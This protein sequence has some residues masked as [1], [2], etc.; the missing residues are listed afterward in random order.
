[1][2]STIVVYQ[3]ICILDSDEP[4]VLRPSIDDIDLFITDLLTLK[5]SHNSKLSPNDSKWLLHQWLTPRAHTII[6][7]RYE[8]MISSISHD[9]QNVASGV[10]DGDDETQWK[11]YDEAPYVPTFDELKLSSADLTYLFNDCARHAEII[12]STA[13]KIFLRQ[14]SGHG[15]NSNID[16]GQPPKYIYHE[17]SSPFA[18]SPRIPTSQGNHDAVVHLLLQPLE[19]QLVYIPRR[20]VVIIDV[21]IPSNDTPMTL[22]WKLSVERGYEVDFGVVLCRYDVEVDTGRQQAIN[23]LDEYMT[24]TDGLRTI[25]LSAP[26]SLDTCPGDQSASVQVQVLEPLIRLQGSSQDMDVLNRIPV[27]PPGESVAIIDKLI[28]LK[29]KNASQ[30]PNGA[31][32]ASSSTW[33]NAENKENLKSNR[34]LSNTSTSTGP[35]TVSY[36]SASASN[37][38]MPEREP[39]LQVCSYDEQHEWLEGSHSTAGSMVRFVFDNSFSNVFG[40]YVEF[41]YQIVDAGIVQVQ[42]A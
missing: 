42:S 15:Y 22:V 9:I 24:R 1:M 30:V 10:G 11:V 3:L 17:P 37:C 27:H 6:N 25:G 8:A 7:D 26:S 5:S 23:V 35:S 40:K 13:F 31:S 21:D 39:H 2:T 38:L 41:A 28:H 20:D 18:R 34:S 4:V 16:I 36:L 33:N 19:P 32:D 12:N 14:C 29:K